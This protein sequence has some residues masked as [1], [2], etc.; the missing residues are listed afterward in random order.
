[1]LAWVLGQGNGYLAICVDNKN[2]YNP[3]TQDQ[4]R[5]TSLWGFLRQGRLA[6][7]QKDSCKST[8][9]LTVFLAPLPKLRV[10]LVF[11]Y[12]HTSR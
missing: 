12:L 1:M 10:C 6:C 5:L 2:S 7:D 3:Q 11:S 9:H 4:V 8:L